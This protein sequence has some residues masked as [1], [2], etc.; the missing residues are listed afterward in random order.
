[1]TKGRR[2]SR[3]AE[4]A[5]TVGDECYAYPSKMG[6]EPPRGKES[7][8]LGHGQCEEGRADTHYNF[9]AILCPAPHRRRTILARSGWRSRSQPGQS[10]EPA[11]PP[12]GSRT[13]ERSAGRMPGGRP[14]PRRSIGRRSRARPGWKRPHGQGVDRSG[15][16][17]RRRRLP[18]L[19]MTFRPASAIFTL[20]VGRHRNSPI[21]SSSAALPGHRSS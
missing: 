18:R 9:G 8:Q 15:I 3:T 2:P 19:Q 6:F 17:H 13:R 14:R 1:M 5:P 11:S 21:N 16:R 7:E 20:T 12:R 4:A 10:A